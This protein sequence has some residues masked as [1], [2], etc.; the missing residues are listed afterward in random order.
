MLDR[1]PC[2]GK[3]EAAGRMRFWWWDRGGREHALCWAIAASP[4]LRKLWCA[5]GNPGIA[6]GGGM[7][8]RSAP[9]DVAASCLRARAEGRL[10]GRRAGGAAGRSVWRR[11][12]GG[13][14][15]VLRAER[16]GRA[17]RGQQGLHQGGLRRRTACRPRPTALHRSGGR[18]RLC[19]RAGRADRGE[20]RWARRR[21][22]RGGR[23]TV[24]EA[25]PPS[26]TS[27]KAAPSA[28]PAPTVV[29]EEC[30]T[31]RRSRFFALCDGTTRCRSPRRRTTSA[32]AMA[33]PGPEHR[34]HGRLF[35]AAV[36]TAAL[37][38]R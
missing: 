20:G 15:Q 29:I 21:Q 22:G 34:R 12:R 36:F 16:G 26:P 3:D 27:W 28:P 13:R 32:S 1:G 14:H 5:P 30:L 2:D 19:P 8:R 18:A 23:A 35:A 37:P 25:K 33:T 10:R 6:R 24:D 9:T 7:R 4:L 17:A 31:A 38:T 11:L